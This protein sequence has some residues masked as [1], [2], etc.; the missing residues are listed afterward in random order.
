MIIP[1]VLNNVNRVI[2]PY[3]AIFCHFHQ[4]T[5]VAH[6]NS[7]RRHINYSLHSENKVI[8]LQN[9]YKIVERQG[10]SFINQL[11]TSHNCVLHHTARYEPV[12]PIYAYINLY[13]E[14]NNEFIS[15]FPRINTFSNRKVTRAHNYHRKTAQISKKALYE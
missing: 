7:I 1:H 6:P 8:F 9:C 15:N 12:Q 10:I 11:E 14:K 3:F 2:L 13:N 4:K 5:L